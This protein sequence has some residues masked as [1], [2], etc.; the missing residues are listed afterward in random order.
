VKSSTPTFLGGGPD[1]FAELANVLSDGRD[2]TDDRD[3]PAMQ[4]RVD[5]DWR[6][7]KTGGKR[8]HEVR[9]VRLVF[10]GWIK[11]RD[12]EDILAE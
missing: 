3:G 7:T 4:M 2:D 10:S 9:D 1:I 11:S 8:R 12:G 5:G 6:E